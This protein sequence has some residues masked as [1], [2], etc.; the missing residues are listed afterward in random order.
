MITVSREPAHV[1]SL[2]L[3]HHQESVLALMFCPH[4]AWASILLIVANMLYNGF[5]DYF[6]PVMAMC[7]IRYR[8]DH[9][10]PTSPL[11]GYVSGVFEFPT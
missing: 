11:P 9:A 8:R 1:D 3:L 4:I 2:H 6:I 7:V 10:E 5:A